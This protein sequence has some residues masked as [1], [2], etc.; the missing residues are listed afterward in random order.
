MSVRF[1]RM[2]LA[3]NAEMPPLTVALAER[4]LECKDDAARIVDAVP[5]PP[6]PLPQCVAA[7]E[8]RASETAVERRRFSWLLPSTPEVINCSK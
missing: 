8:R 4:F 5:L 1:P 7:P 2:T 6:R 3:N